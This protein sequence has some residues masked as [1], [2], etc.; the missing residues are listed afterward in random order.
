MKGPR[1]WSLR[2]RLMGLAAVASLL[3]WLA[4]GIAVLFA[5]REQGE[6]LHD[7]RLEEVARV[8]LQFAA[9]EI[10]EINAERPGD[11]VHLETTRTL[12]GRYRYQVW[13]NAG[14]LLLVSN[15]TPRDRFAPPGSAGH[16]AR[17]VDGQ[18]YRVFA[19][20]SHDGAMQIQVAER[21]GLRDLF[22]GTVDRY[23]I[24]VFIATTAVL[25]L[26]N[27]WMFG[28]TTRAFDA[29][30]RQLRDRTADDPRPIDVDDP[31]RELQPMLDALNGL[32]RRFDH[33][34]GSE[35]HFTAAAA[36]ELRTTLAAVRIQAQVAERA[37]VPRDAHAAL[38]Q[39]GTCVERASRLIDQLLTLARIDMTAVSHATAT[40]V[41]LDVLAARVAS[42]MAPLLQAHGIAL[43]TDLQPVEV[44][45]FEFG[46]AAVLRNLLDNAARHCPQDGR[47]RLEIRRS[48][49]EGV[50]AVDDSGPG[51]AVEEREQVL[52]PFYRPQTNRHRTDGSGVGL[53]IVRSVANAHQGRVVLSDSD[54][55]GLRVAVHIGIRLA[56]QSRSQTPDLPDP[57][58]PPSAGH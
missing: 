37:R 45:G 3:A 10:G 28:R 27:W 25:L 39:L 6:Q 9:H 49:G 14:A 56:S 1:E 51:I 38:E 5:A 4:G 7:T 30:A 2:N 17:T 55:G 13:S 35:R 20:D 21:L 33:A 31:P 12:D 8:I 46:L 26:L 43:T 48:N 15:D 22:V 52:E 16:F 50:I 19:L 41:R 47:V 40:P 11:I 44:M 34:L 29:A 58:T 36:H 32:F 23:L 24:V 57:S 18:A 53:S 54:L 42:E